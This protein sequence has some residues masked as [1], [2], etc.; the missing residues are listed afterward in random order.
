MNFLKIILKTIDKAKNI[1]YN[2]SRSRRKSDSTI[3]EKKDYEKDHFYN[4][5]MRTPSRMR[6]V[7]HLLQ[8]DAL[9]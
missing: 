6:Y 7:I 2:L 4:S 9:R 1:S 8:Q 3:K 5:R